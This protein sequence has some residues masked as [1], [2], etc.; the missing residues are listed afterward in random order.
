M[1]HTLP[2]HPHDREAAGTVWVRRIMSV[3]DGIAKPVRQ[4]GPR[5]KMPGRNG[6]DGSACAGG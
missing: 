3:R 1:T 2:A 5:R 6:G 4:Q